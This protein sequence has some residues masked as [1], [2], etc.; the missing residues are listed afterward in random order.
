MKIFNLKYAILLNVFLLCFHSF[1]QANPQ[2]FKAVLYGVVQ[3][4]V[5]GFPSFQ[6]LQKQQYMNKFS[7]DYLRHRALCEGT[8]IS[9]A[10]Q[11]LDGLSDKDIKEYSY[12][13]QLSDERMQE[14]QKHIPDYVYGISEF[15][16][17]CQYA[18]MYNIL[19]QARRMNETF[20]FDYPVKSFEYLAMYPLKNLE[21][22]YAEISKIIATHERPWRSWWSVKYAFLSKK[23]N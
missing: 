11:N 8:N 5:K 19:G 16:Q 7:Y 13:Y 4:K 9:Y 10:L 23:N 6:M 3:A 14:L 12:P 18:C 22:P 20:E 1:I 17:E 21:K 15:D 2:L